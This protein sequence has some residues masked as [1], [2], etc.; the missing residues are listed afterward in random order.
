MDCHTRAEMGIYHR[1][2]QECRRT[3]RRTPIVYSCSRIL[4]LAVGP[5]VR[6]LTTPM[7]WQSHRRQ[8]SYSLTAEERRM[9][10]VRHPRNK[11]DSSNDAYTTF[12][13]PRWPIH[14]V[15]RVVLS[16]PIHNVNI[17]S[18]FN[19]HIRHRL[20]PDFDT[21]GTPPVAS[22]FYLYSSRPTPCGSNNL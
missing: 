5:Q 12:L 14:R 17:L 2:T 9:K 7:A 15:L 8:L 4:P 16:I 6:T 19:I 11:R 22:S 21:T 13:P 3:P 1:Q 20:I 10:Y 18:D